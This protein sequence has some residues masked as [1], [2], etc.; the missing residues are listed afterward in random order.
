[1]ARHDRLT[2]SLLREAFARA[3]ILTSVLEDGLV[4]ADAAAKGILT[5]SSKPA[6]RGILTAS[7]N[8]GVLTRGILTASTDAGILTRGILT[9]RT[10]GRTIGRVLVTKFA[11]FGLLSKA[12]VAGA[13][14]TVA[15]SSAGAAGVLP[16]PAQ[17]AFDDVVGRQVAA[18]DEGVDEDDVDFAGEREQGVD[19]GIVAREATADDG[20]P[21][22]DGREVAE[23][24][25]DGRAGGAAAVDASD[26]R[27]A[28]E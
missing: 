1:M 27:V 12:A 5:F 21:G 14:M 17:V 6:D 2:E 18:A 9:M 20:V 24:A 22:V 15:A 25:S 7:T 28:G 16:P 10:K 4:A 11:A 13:T 8:N 26:R 3:G 19:G 23:D